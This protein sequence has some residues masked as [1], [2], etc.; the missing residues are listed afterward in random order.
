MPWRRT[1][2]VIEQAWEPEPVSLEEN[3]RARERECEFLRSENRRLQ[4]MV[5]TD[6]QAFEAKMVEMGD[7]FIAQQAEIRSRDREVS[8][9]RAALKR[10]QTALRESA[11]GD[12]AT[13][14]AARL[15]RSMMHAAGLTAQLELVHET[16]PDSPLFEM[17]GETF[18]DGRPK[19]RLRLAYEAAFDA[20][21]ADHQV[22]APQTLRRR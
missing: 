5:D 9:L 4:R 3:L 17:A 21:G 7:T 20:F 11:V 13:G 19:T 6:G 12:S 15:R 8:H 1:R 10:T 14:L 2:P 18:A 16:H 22:E